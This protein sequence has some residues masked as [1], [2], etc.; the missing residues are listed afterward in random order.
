MPGERPRRRVVDYL[1]V[2]VPEHPSFVVRGRVLAVHADG[3]MDIEDWSKSPFETR[4]IPNEGHILEELG[5]FLPP[6][7]PASRGPRRIVDF[8]PVGAPEHP[9]FVVRGRVV[10]THADGS[11]DIEDLD[12]RPGRPPQLRWIPDEGY[13]VEDFGDGHGC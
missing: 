10:R 11:M 8:L 2:G 1:P 9:S 12:R 5:D 3:S 13:I 4:R 6:K 7:V